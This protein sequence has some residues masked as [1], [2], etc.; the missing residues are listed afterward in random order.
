MAKKTIREDFRIRVDADA[1]SEEQ[2]GDYLE[3]TLN[4]MI[5]DIKRHV[6]GVGWIG[7]VW[8]SRD[9]CEFCNR[10]WEVSEEPGEGGLPLCYGKA[11][12]EWE[13][14]RDMEAYHD[15]E[16]SDGDGI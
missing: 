11:H 12:E 15:K 6:D 14:I 7:I 2:G 3:R 4:G 1:Y 13:A 8:D 5:T 10:N 9:V 16:P